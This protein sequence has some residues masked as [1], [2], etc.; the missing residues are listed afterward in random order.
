MNKRTELHDST[1]FSEDKVWPSC[2]ISDHPL[3]VIKKYETLKYLLLL[4]C[5]LNLFKLSDIEKQKFKILAHQG[6]VSNFPIK[7]PVMGHLGD[8]V[9]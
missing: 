2:G 1:C 6:L 8:S 5:I 7:S 3:Y 4:S 9:S